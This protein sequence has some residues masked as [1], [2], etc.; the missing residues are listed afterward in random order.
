LQ[1]EAYSELGLKNPP[2]SLMQPIRRGALEQKTEQEIYALKPGGVTTIK[3]IPSAY[4]FYRLESRRTVPLQ[5]ATPEISYL[6]YRQRLGK[7]AK[8]L[9]GSLRAEYNEKYFSAVDHAAPLSASAEAQTRKTTE[10][11]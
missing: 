3:D 5:E 6:L 10:T 4:V 7:F 1:R 2:A 8:A 11:R 9:T